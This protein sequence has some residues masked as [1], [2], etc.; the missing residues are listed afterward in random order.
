MIRYALA[1]LALTG[2]AHAAD[3]YD[4]HS[5]PAVV[6]RRVTA[7][8]APIRMLDVAADEPGRIVS[9]A[10][11]PGDRVPGGDLAIVRLDAELADLA[12]ATAE[13]QLAARRRDAEWHAQDRAH[14]ER[15][16]ERAEKIFAEGRM[17]EQ[18]RDAALRE[19]DRARGMAAA[20]IG[21]IAAAE[22]ELAAAKTRRSHRDVR[23][24]ANWVVIERLREPGAMVAAGEPILR[25]AD[26]SELVVQV[27]LDESELAALR[28]AAAATALNLHFAGAKAAIP[29]RIRQVDVT[30]DPVSRKR[31]V[32]IAIDGAAAPEASGG[33]VTELRLAIP[34][35][36]GGLLVP[37]ELVEW[38]LEQAWVRT[39]EGQELPV[40][41][42]RRIDTGIVIAADALPIGTTL[43]AQ[44]KK[45]G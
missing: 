21:I 26:V 25:L 30:F 36:S 12:V 13:A 43:A 39:A 1:L 14:A 35:P 17:A 4:P 15:T 28:A 3:Q 18:D 7:Y 20:D 16:A 38:R 29:A 2:S 41:P 5:H 10:V 27:R 24:P 33:L 34:D 44:P 9:I 45:D 19:R 23:A 40:Q 8:T 32:E 42:L 22:A 6:A 37:N 31:M 11:Q